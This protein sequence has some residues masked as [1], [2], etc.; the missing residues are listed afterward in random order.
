MAIADLRREYNFMA[1][2]RSDL[3]PD[4]IAQFRKWFDQA[5]GA[6]TSGKVRSFCIKLYKK[7]FLITGGEPM[8]L[9]AMTLATVDKEG[10]PSARVVLLK[11]VD[12]R[13]FVFFTNY[14][15]RKGKELAGNPHAAL[16][17]Y[18]SDQVRQ[19]CVSGE[20]CQLP[21]AESDAYFRTRPRG[22]QL[23][24][25]ASQQSSVVPDRAALES[26]WKEME[27]RFTSI[28]GPGGAPATVLGRLSAFPHAHRV[29]A[30]PA[31]PAPRPLP[32]HAAA[33]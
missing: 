12:E 24:A 4:P 3:E 26:R 11:G 2:R 1:L 15:S 33:G 31:Q 18:W 20:V 16:I 22:S 30:R 27:A 29:L 28:R 13:G 23:E 21:P 9:T 6:R 14:E 7:L 8:D 32:L 19:V 10:H 5:A 25:W 17:F